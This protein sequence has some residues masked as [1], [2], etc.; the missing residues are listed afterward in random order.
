[1]IFFTVEFQRALMKLQALVESLQAR[2]IA[3]QRYHPGFVLAYAD[4]VGFAADIN[5]LAELY[6]IYA[7]L[8]LRISPKSV[9]VNLSDYL[10]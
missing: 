8:G 2:L 5:V 10:I 9:M 1:M 3:N 6:K 7:T 4:E